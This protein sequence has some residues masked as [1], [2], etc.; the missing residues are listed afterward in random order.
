MLVTHLRDELVDDE[1]GSAAA[2]T[3]DGP[4][5]ARATTTRSRSWAWAAATPAAPARRT[6]CG[7]WSTTGVDAIGLPRQPRLG[8]RGPV[9]PRPG[10]RGKTYTRHGGFLDEADRFDTEFFGISPREALAMD[11]QQRLLLQTAWE[12]LEHAGIRPD[13]LRAAAPASSWR[14]SRRSTARWLTRDG[15]LERLS[16][17]GNTASV[18]SGRIS[19]TFG[20][21][22]PAVTVDT[23]CSSSLVAMHLAVPGAAGR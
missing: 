4:A 5:A 8:P 12:A 3:A 15:G 20:L 18:A 23:A 9:R 11:P 2:V 19:Y 13:G 22:G 1:P 6:S 21:E 7:G 17:T 16:A 10:V 14:R